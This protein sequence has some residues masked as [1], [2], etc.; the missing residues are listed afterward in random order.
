MNLVR[1]N[2]GHFYDSDKFA[3]CPHCS[4]GSDIPLCVPLVYAPP[5]SGKNVPKAHVLEQVYRI[6][7]FKASNCN[8]FETRVFEFPNKSLNFPHCI[9]TDLHSQKT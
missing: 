8:A 3:V 1:C 9:F 6:E 7:D 2:N 5:A 4:G